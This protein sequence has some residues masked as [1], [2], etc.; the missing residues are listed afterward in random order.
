MIRVLTINDLSHV[1]L[2]PFVNIVRLY[3]PGR[4]RKLSSFSSICRCYI[5][6]W[7]TRYTPFASVIISSGVEAELVKRYTLGKAWSL[8]DSSLEICHGARNP[9]FCDMSLR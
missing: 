3:E 7:F 2:I 8:A 6:P 5:L 9:S 1:T 4:H